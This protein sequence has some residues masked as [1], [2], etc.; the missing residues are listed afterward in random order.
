VVS[1][2]AR[3]LGEF[4]N[5]SLWRENIFGNFKMINDEVLKQ[6]KG[7]L[8]NVE[9]NYEIFYHTIGDHLKSIESKDLLPK[10]DF[11]QREN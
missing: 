2:F 4:A 8:D 7:Q 6:F 9:K 5:S 11:L 3:G 1:C 10:L